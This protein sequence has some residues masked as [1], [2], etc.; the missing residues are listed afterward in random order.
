VVV[1]PHHG[2]GAL[3]VEL[4]LDRSDLGLDQRLAGGGVVAEHLHRHHAA[5]ADAAAFED[6]AGRVP[7]RGQ[8]QVGQAQAV[9]HHHAH[10]RVVDVGRHGGTVDGELELVGELRLS[11]H[12]GSSGFS[13]W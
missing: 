2:Q 4:G 1:A 3:G 7:E 9:V 11:G 5:D 13:G 10:E 6:V 8:E 12:G